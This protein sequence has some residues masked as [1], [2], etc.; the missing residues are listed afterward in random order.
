MA[1]ITGKL[2]DALRGTLGEFGVQVVRS[3]A[4]PLPNRLRRSNSRLIR[5]YGSSGSPKK[6]HLG[7]GFN[8]LPGWLNTDLES[9]DTVVYLDLTKKFPLENDTF[10]YVF[11]EHAIE[12]IPY[13]HGLG[14]LREAFRVLRPGGKIRVVTPDF[15]FLKALYSPQKTPLQEAYIAWANAQ[16]LNGSAPAYAE[17]HVT[18]NFFRNWGHQFIYDQPSL[19]GALETAGFTGIKRFELNESDDA[20]YRGLENETRMPPGF[21]RLESIVLEAVKAGR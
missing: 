2:K 12:H 21:L 18:N 17:M 7:C 4:A 10:D 6:L 14:M 1:T 19:T 8:V 5:Q 13:E 9:S 16:W 3:P 20:V 15:A 11:T